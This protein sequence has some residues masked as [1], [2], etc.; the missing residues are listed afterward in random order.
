MDDAD[1]VG[2]S[3]PVLSHDCESSEFLGILECI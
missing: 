1:I 3:I 2:V